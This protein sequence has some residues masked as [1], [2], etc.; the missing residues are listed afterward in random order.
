VRLLLWVFDTAAHR[1]W[2]YAR[3]HYP[4]CV[5][6]VRVCVREVWIVHHML[7]GSMFRFYVYLTAT[8]SY[9]S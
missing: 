1:L 4:T 9:K 5:S 2:G 3:W 8:L 6:V 7:T